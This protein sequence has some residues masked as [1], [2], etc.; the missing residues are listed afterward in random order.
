MAVMDG[1]VYHL[2]QDAT[3]GAHETNRPNSL[4]LSV[5][6]PNGNSIGFSWD[7]LWPGARPKVLMTGTDRKCRIWTWLPITVSSNPQLVIS[8]KAQNSVQWRDPRYGNVLAM[9]P[10]LSQ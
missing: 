3:V 5:G 2:Q 4:H 9:L 10:Y 8:Y 1:W 7:A 6:D